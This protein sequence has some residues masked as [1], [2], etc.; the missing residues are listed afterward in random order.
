MA[1]PDPSAAYNAATTSSLDQRFAEAIVRFRW[2]LTILVVLGVAALLSMGMGRV[3]HVTESVAKLG[4]TTSGAG[5]APPIVFDPRMDVWF[6]AEDKAVDTYAEIEDRFV[7][8]D[9]VVVSFQ[10]D[11]DDEFGVFSPVHL[12]RVAR[13]TDQFLAVP[14]VRHVRS[15]T[16]NPW[17]RW[18]TIQ[19][20]SGDEEGLLITDLVEGD[21]LQLSDSDVI[22]RMIAVLGAQGAADRVGEARVREI[23]GAEP[24]ENYIG[25]PL[26]LGAIVDPA[27]QTTA[28]QIQVLRPRPNAEQLEA[29]FGDDVA[30]GDVAK[31]LWTIQ[32]QRTALRG[33]RH[34]LGLDLG[35][36]IP[37]EDLAALTAYV[38]G[39]PAGE[40][41]EALATEL[42]D[43]SR[44][45][46]ANADG[47]VV[48]K[49]FEYEPDG[50]GGWV[51]RSNPGD[52]VA[53]PDGWSPKPTDTVQYHLGGVPVFELN[54]EQVG[55]ADGKYIPLM[56][57]V[58]M[59]CLVIV[60]R[61]AV[62]VFA[63]IAVVF[64][65][66][67]GMM[68][69]AFARG[70]LLNN[71]TMM[72]PNMLTAV[73]IADAIHLIAA[74]AM[75]RTRFDDKRELL[76]EVM[77]VNALPVLLTSVTTAIG[78]YSLMASD[79]IPVRM[80]GY[81]AGLGAL[82]A[83]LLS[84]T[85]VP[86]LLSLVPHKG[87]VP[88]SRAWLS[89]MFTDARA[90][91][92]VQR[93]IRRRVLILGVAGVVFAI[94]AVGVAR[95]QINSDF[96]EMFPDDNIVVEDFNWIEGQL[97][98]LG[99]VELIFRGVNAAGDAAAQ[100]LS[101]DDEARLTE[102][103]LAQMVQQSGEGEALTDDEASELA[104]LESLNEA[105]QAARIGVAPEFLGSLDRLE[106]RLRSEMEQEGSALSVLSDLTSPL[107]I[108]RK[109]HQVQNENEAALY[110]V[111]NPSDVA[112]DQRE[113]RLEYD[114]FMEEWSLT[115]GQDA[116]SLVAQYYLQYE[117]GARPGENLSTQL[118]QDRMQFRMQGRMKQAPTT[119]HLAAFARVEEVVSA[120]FPELNVSLSEGAVPTPGTADMTLSGKTLLN[121]RTMRLF[122]TGFVKSMSIAL[123]MITIIIGCLFRSVALA[124]VSLLPNV[125]PILLPLSAFGL[126]GVPLDGP[127]IL[128]SS[129]ALGVCVDDTIHFFTKFVRARRSGESLEDS[130]VY[131][132]TQAGG[133]LTITTIVLIIG[134]GTLL[135]SDFT[136]NFMMGTLA[137]LMIALAWA[138]DFIVTPALLSLLP[139]VG[140]ARASA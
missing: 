106:R 82:F 87:A 68:G 139:N 80:L 95:I 46:M 58:I 116:R 125:L 98:G 28:I 72:S 73:G 25:E 112:A 55:L 59:V 51:D 109:I 76:V 24:F 77:R 134:F 110:R 94:S 99:D 63:P 40:A 86:A 61:H 108:L 50:S 107:D 38:E 14:G 60:F 117:N 115:P 57:L 113:P 62:G 3:M 135:L 26:L 48:R 120:E 88:E 29:S 39:L 122:S 54:F 49:Y 92:L 66:I 9:Y 140:R 126:V 1:Q 44:N 35:T 31:G 19:D 78:F 124:L 33:I 37:T 137:T 23:I 27:A 100:P 5:S 138:L 12:D 127:A 30:T 11:E 90:R 97:G 132:M 52:A 111:P 74:W 69:F 96:R 71:L 20:D 17:I 4:D 75:F 93:L 103:T 114:E 118:S 121:A 15:L 45:F 131:A 18:G 7:A 128:V 81:T 34:Y 32:M 16:Y 91:G 36:T 64:G 22:E 2:P 41:R 13:L 133:A 10:A 85:V 136:P 42:R 67:A 83:Y 101:E 43:P 47:E 123:V 119:A 89:G 129:V 130:L 65:S 21:P 102:L 84:M 104:A 105:W 79:L 56:F 8:E 70:D 53:A 6:G